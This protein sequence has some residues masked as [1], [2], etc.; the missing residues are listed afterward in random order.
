MFVSTFHPICTTETKMQL[1]CFIALLFLDYARKLTGFA[2]G[3]VRFVL[4][5]ATLRPR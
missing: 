4:L 5:I 1:A 3:A 2:N